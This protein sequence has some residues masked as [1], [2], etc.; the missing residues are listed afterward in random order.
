[1]PG[2][3]DYINLE[4]LITPLVLNYCQCMLELQEYYTVLE[5]TSELLEKHKGGLPGLCCK[6]P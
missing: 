5:Q 3:E 6:R 4:R 1:M 2:H